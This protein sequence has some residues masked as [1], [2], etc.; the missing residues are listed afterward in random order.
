MVCQLR[1]V[2]QALNAWPNAGKCT[3]VGQIG[4]G[5]FQELAHGIVLVNHDPRLRLQLP[6]TQANP[7]ALPI[8]LQDVDLY[9][10]AHFQ[11]LAGVPNLA[12]GEFRE[13]DQTI[14][15]AQI[16]EGPEIGQTGHHSLADVSLVQLLQQLHFLL[17]PPVSHRQ[18]LGEDEAVALAV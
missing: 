4:D 3:E 10:L 1:D 9:L 6:Q 17:T 8:H 2:N 15:S 13:V 7:F 5:A 11:H 16:Y 14:G 18:A 12:P